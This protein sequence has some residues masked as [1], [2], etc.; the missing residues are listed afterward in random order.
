M[1]FML[2]HFLDLALMIDGDEEEVLHTLMDNRVP[3]SLCAAP[4]CFFG[5]CCGSSIVTRR[6]FRAL[7]RR[8]YQAPLWQFILTMMAVV[9]EIAEINE[10]IPPVN[11]NNIIDSSLY[12]ILK[13]LIT[14]DREAFVPN[15][16]R[17]QRLGVHVWQLGF[18]RHHQ[19]FQRTG[20]VKLESPHGINTILPSY[21][22][23][24]QNFLLFFFK[25]KS[26]CADLIYWLH[27][28]SNLRSRL[29]SGLHGSHS[30]F[31]SG[32]LHSPREA[33]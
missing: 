6:G 25:E 22:I 5:L 7:R 13:C 19:N 31:S 27:E 23:N 15:F 30:V 16:G 4:C 11:Y 32:H 18:Q 21:T 12:L 33:K 1:P 2:M 9:L 26:A 20:T 28:D 10:F 14:V 24:H 29:V 8:V 3:L 17:T